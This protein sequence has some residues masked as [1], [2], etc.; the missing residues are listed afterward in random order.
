MGQITQL[1][2]KIL[3]ETERKYNLVRKKHITQYVELSQEARV[4]IQKRIEIC[5]N[6]FIFKFV[7]AEFAEYLNVLLEA[8][9]NEFVLALKKSTSC[10]DAL[11]KRT[12][13]AE[14]ERSG[15]VKELRSICEKQ[16]E[17]AVESPLEI[18]NL[19]NIWGD[20][21]E[22]G[23]MD[24]KAS[25]FCNVC[26]KAN[27][28]TR[29]RFMCYCVCCKGWYHIFSCGGVNGKQISDKQKYLKELEE[30][31]CTLCEKKCFVVKQLG[32][33]KQKVK[34]VC[35]EYK[36]DDYFSFKIV[37]EEDLIETLHGE[38]DNLV[39]ELLTGVDMWSYDAKKEAMV[40]VMKECFDIRMKIFLIQKIEAAKESNKAIWLKV[41][42]AWGVSALRKFCSYISEHWPSKIIN[43]TKIEQAY[44]RFK[45]ML[46]HLVVTGVLQQSHNVFH[47]FWRRKTKYKGHWTLDQEAER[48]FNSMPILFEGLEPYLRMYDIAGAFDSIEAKI[49]SLGKHCKT[50]LVDR[51]SLDEEHFAYELMLKDNLRDV[52]K[53]EDFIDKAVKMFLMFKKNK[54]PCIPKSQRKYLVS[55]VVDRIVYAEREVKLKE[56]EIKQL[57]SAA[58]KN[59]EPE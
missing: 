11:L 10:Y 23:V 32:R 39:K 20:V 15:L 14:Y 28:F 38:W 29:D 43:E 48:L 50:L 18:E 40:L 44:Q 13:V 19:T 57:V 37:E 8:E 25:Q 30:W 7:E 17:R 2:A 41:W 35:N 34:Q 58:F 36:E 54:G 45:H 56:D 33:K 26:F 27:L 5:N 9:E 22:N 12:D 47:R 1:Q 46:K 6:V 53:N 51:G 16:A 24:G 3:T 49:E 4:E 21:V 59:F 31:T 42:K 55:R 52:G